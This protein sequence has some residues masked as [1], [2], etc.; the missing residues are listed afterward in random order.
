MALGEF[1]SNDGSRKKTKQ[2]HEANC[3]R[4]MDTS[5]SQRNNFASCEAHYL[6]VWILL[7]SKNE[8]HFQPLWW[9]SS[10]VDIMTLIRTEEMGRKKRE[11][12]IRSGRE[13]NGQRKICGDLHHEMA[14]ILLTSRADWLPSCCLW[15]L[16]F[17]DA[18]G[19][20]RGGLH[21]PW[22]CRRGSS[23]LGCEKPTAAWKECGGNEN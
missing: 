2:I 12:K 1:F 5:C 17:Q 20:I 22:G 3:S 19:N 16:C 21:L 18:A 6:I 11:H 23:R 15:T 7:Y 14:F 13:K 4:Y 10:D 8:E 9:C